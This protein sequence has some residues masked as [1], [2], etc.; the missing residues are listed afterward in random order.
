M[1]GGCVAQE[2]L[3]EDTPCPRSGVEAERSYPT[4]KVKSTGGE[5]KPHIQGKR[6][7]SKIAGAERGH[8]RAGI[9]KPQSQKTN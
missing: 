1:S 9:L 5:E 4:P 8:Q 3:R 6:N 7:P 2:R